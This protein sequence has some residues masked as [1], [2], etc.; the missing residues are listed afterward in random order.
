MT[1]TNFSSRFSQ[2]AMAAMATVVPAIGFAGARK[3]LLLALIVVVVNGAFVLPVTHAQQTLGAVSGSVTDATGAVIPGASITLVNDQT[4]ATRSTTSNN[5][6]T[7]SVQDLF[8]GTYTLTIAAPG[9]NTQRLNGVRVQADRTATL[10]IRLK[11]G[12]VS[13]TVDVTATPQLNT[14]DT[15]NGYVLDSATIELTPLGTGSFTQLATLGPGVQADLLADTGTNTGLGNQ[16]IYSNGQRLSSN[17]FTFNGVVTN[18]LFNG[19]SSSQVTESRAVLNTGAS[20]QSNGAIRTNT[21]IFDAIGESLPT[22]PQQTIAEERVNTSMFDAAQGATAGAHIDVTTKSGTNVLHGSVYGNFETSKLNANPFFNKQ[23]GNPNPDLHRYL[24]GAELGG[25]ILTNKLFFYASYQY[26]RD[27]D[28]LNSRTSYFAP[29]GIT[30][31]R[32]V[33]GLQPVLAAAGLPP[34]TPIDPVA[35]AYLQAKLPDGQFLIRSPASTLARINFT[36]P[37]SKFQADQANGNLNFVVS[38]KDTISS[39]YYFQQD[40]TESPFS[41]TSLLGFPQKFHAGSQ[42]FSLENTTILSPRFTWNQKAGIVRQTVT[43]F[44]GQPF[45][46][47]AVG[48]NLFG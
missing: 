27:R 21:S 16:N 3:A 36:G 22:P 37:A 13:T 45:G 31:D 6:G 35:L 32:S 26:T 39:K 7:Y 41:S 9:F 33:A 46:P 12:A 11:P 10:S 47:S 25:P 15:T 42:V 4:T 17:T 44:T 29:L 48:I 34:G 38:N 8:I 5:T 14:V 18:N 24:A 23:T 19:A 20:F 30:D 1:S 40:P 2:W 43:S 28:Q